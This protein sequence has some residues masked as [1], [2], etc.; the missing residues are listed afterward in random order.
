MA[1][2]NRKIKCVKMVVDI[3][4]TESLTKEQVQEVAN[5]VSNALYGE[6]YDGDGFS[7]DNSDALTEKIRVFIP[8]T[9]LIIDIPF[10]GTKLIRNKTVENL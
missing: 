5:R 6:V 7:P 3:T 1:K 4:F 2:N 8:E 10:A 9:I